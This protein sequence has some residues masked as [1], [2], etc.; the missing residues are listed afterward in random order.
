MRRVAIALSC[1][2]AV[3][4]SWPAAAADAYYTY[5]YANVEAVGF[6]NP[7]YTVNL[8]RYAL[9]MDALLT[10]LLNIHTTARVRAH[11]YALA[12]ALDKL[13]T[14]KDVVNSYR[15]HAYD[16][17]I[18]MPAGSYWGAAFG[19]T[20]ALLADAQALKGPYWYQVGV[21]A[22]FAGTVFEH[23]KARL[24]TV[25]NGAAIT[26]TERGQRFPLRTF[27]AMTREDVLA[28][29][30]ANRIMF[31][32]E[33][34]F[35][36][37]EVFVESIHRTEFLKYLELMHS[38]TAEPDAFSSAFNSLSYEALDK[39]FDVAF[40]QRPKI[41]T[42]DIPADPV[43]AA[44]QAR[45]LS[46]LE[47]TAVT[48]LLGTERN[49]LEPLPLAHQVLAVDANNQTALRALALGS[50][51][52]DNFADALAAIDKLD[53]LNP[54]PEA[55]ADSAIVLGLLS[56]AEAGGKVTLSV[57]AAT[58]QARARAADLKAIGN[59]GLPAHPDRGCS[60]S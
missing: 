31:E 57:D 39:E 35:V 23:G 52:H 33:A 18:I 51:H 54:T 28:L 20:G 5:S 1:L 49:K 10:K 44:A 9:Q 47:V 41:Y 30:D 7:A 8:V 29:S 55:F 58:L 13:A 15:V 43:P 3:S 27:L 4:A 37:H 45:R 2:W 46:E 60:E 6:D 24:G 14:Q 40:H 32:A 53:A 17:I 42:M 25:N 38:G 22:V 11:L 21:P 19:Y 50:V 12:P 56:C 48:A 59:T 26:L 36:A 34:W 16:A